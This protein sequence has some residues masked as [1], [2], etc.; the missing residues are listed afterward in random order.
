MVCLS[1]NLWFSLR[2]GGDHHGKMQLL[3]NQSL[4]IHIVVINRT[5]SWLILNMKQKVFGIFQGLV[6]RVCGLDTSTLRESPFAHFEEF[7]TR[8]DR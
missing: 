8:V 5:P 1:F 3:C 7:M 6:P 2:Y 4:S